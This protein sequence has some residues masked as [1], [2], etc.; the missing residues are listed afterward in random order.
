MK[1]LIV[2]ADDFGLT[3]NVNRAILDGHCRGVITSTSLLANG[4]AFESAV[5][6]ARQASRLG[7]GVH[8]NLTEG[9]PVATGLDIPSL[10]NGRGRFKRAPAGLWRA[11]VSGR[12]SAAHIEKE[13]RAQIEKVLATGVVPTHLDSH[14]HVHALPAL[15]KMAIKLAPEYRV[16]AIRCLAERRR[17]AGR[18]L[19][20]YPRATRTVLRQLSNSCALAAVSRRWAGELERAGLVCASDFYGLTATG[21]LDEETMREILSSLRDGT[22]ELMCHPGWVDDDLRRTPTRLVGQRETEFR[23]LTS[24]AIKLQARDLGIQLVN[25]RDIARV[26]AT[27]VLA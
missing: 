19:W 10:V 6:L 12:V 17:G 24:P 5:A 23:A 1:R 27:R 4:E 11:L 21:F 16:P 22:S 8:L 15:G 9:K 13:L 26:N 2:N 3:A 18:L 20:R 25:Y 14:K 7:V